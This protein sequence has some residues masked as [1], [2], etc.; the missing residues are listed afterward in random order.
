MMRGGP[1]PHNDQPPCGP[2]HA[3]FHTQQLYAHLHNGR[4]HLVDNPTEHE[5]DHQPINDWYQEHHPALL[6][7]SQVDHMYKFFIQ[8]YVQVEESVEVC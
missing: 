6:W 3:S 4:V 8:S 1:N 5:D 7:T 2:G